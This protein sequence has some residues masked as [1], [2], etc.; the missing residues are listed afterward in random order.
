MDRALQAEDLVWRWDDVSA[1]RTLTRV[2]LKAQGEECVVEPGKGRHGWCLGSSL[3]E[4]QGEGVGGHTQT[5]GSS[6]SS[7]KRKGTGGELPVP[8]QNRGHG[9]ASLCCREEFC[10][11][12]GSLQNAGAGNMLGAGMGSTHA[13]NPDHTRV[14]CRQPPEHSG[15]WGGRSASLVYFS[16]HQLASG[17][18]HPA[19]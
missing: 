2:R 17:C 10:T 16:S 5:C 9:G 18:V 7:I 19:S 6:S 12:K 11:Q 13:T 15:S 1:C 3:V 14:P 8:P 4:S